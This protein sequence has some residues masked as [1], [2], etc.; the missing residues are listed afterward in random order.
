M[1]SPRLRRLA[2]LL[3][4]PLLFLFTSCMRMQ[5]NF[6]IKSAE[7]VEVTMD[8]GLQKA[9]AEQSGETMTKEELCEES[10]TGS[11]PTDGLNDAKTEPYDDGTYIGC[12][13]TGWAPAGTLSSSGS[14]INLTDGVWT[15]QMSGDGSTG[16][17]EA[18]QAAAMLSDFK[19]SV[20]FPGKVLT[21]NGT[22][23]VDGKTATWTSA[24]DLFTA[25]GLKATAEDGSGGIPIW[26]WAIVGVLGLAAIGALVW[27]LMNERKKKAAA[28][29]QQGMQQPW[30]AGAAGP[31]GQ[32][33]YNQPQYGQPGSQPSAPQ[34][35]QWDPN[36]QNQYQNP[37][38]QQWGQQPPS[39]GWT[40]PPPPQR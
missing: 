4:V 11:K 26:V 14:T 10:S 38:N 17:T 24:K 22:S 16:G 30:D 19:V 40:P 18:S 5:A 29:Q 12:K 27:Y 2:I 28:A 15:F 21:H 1:T 6:D 35:P 25:E 37:Q 39:S 33:Q 34:P 13:V 31:Y 32:Q 7:R 36:Q 8:V 9:L 23:T 3:A 20:T